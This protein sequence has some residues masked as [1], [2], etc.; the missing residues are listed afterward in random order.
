[1]KNLTT[2]GAAMATTKKLAR[3]YRIDERVS[4]ALD[5]LREKQK[6]AVANVI[7]DR[8]HFLAYAADREK[9]EI[10][11]KRSVYAL[12][13]PSDLR[14]IYQISGDD[15]VVLD[16]MGEAVLRRYGAKKKPSQSSSPKK[17]VM[18]SGSS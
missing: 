7:R 16:L 17:T 4:I 8:D 2:T 13:V 14:I 3:G 15:I 5:A 9:F 10:S 12:S 18:L 6:K 11:K 1:V